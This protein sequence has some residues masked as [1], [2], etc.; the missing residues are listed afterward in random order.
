M[1][2]KFLKEKLHSWNVN[3][4]K[5]SSDLGYKNDQRLHQ[6]F[7][8]ENVSSTLIEN[9]AKVL[10]RSI[11]DFYDDINKSK[12]HQNYESVSRKLQKTIESQQDTIDRLTSILNKI[13]QKQI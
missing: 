13:S 7:K 3:F 2:G 9:I 5:L 11:T 10:N 12:D 6:R 1:K 8:A 4:S